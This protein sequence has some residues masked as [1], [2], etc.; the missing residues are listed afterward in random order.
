MEDEVTYN[1]ICYLGILDT[2]KLKK[3]G[4][5]IK[6]DY[7]IIDKRFRW[8]VRFYFREPAFPK[9]IMKALEQFLPR[10]DQEEI[11]YGKNMVFFR[12]YAYTALVKKYHQYLLDINNKCRKIQGCLLKNRYQNKLRKKKEIIKKIQNYMKSILVFDKYHRSF[13]GIIKIQKAIK[14][15]IDNL[16]QNRRIKNMMIVQSYIKKEVCRK[17]RLKYTRSLEIIVSAIQRYKIRKL[18]QKYAIIN[19]IKNLIIEKSFKKFTIKQKNTI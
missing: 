8:L 13:K 5:C 12:D 10:F 6:L 18:V 14:S 3:L 1:Q 17:Y 7:E 9:E 16:K 11:L 15:K 2:I 4:Y 19:M